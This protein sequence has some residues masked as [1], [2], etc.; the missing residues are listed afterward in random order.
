M[1]LENKYII[2]K[3]KFEVV[4]KY[5]SYYL[6][7]YVSTIKSRYEKLLNTRIQSMITIKLIS[8]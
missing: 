3:N 2:I 7:V 6:K 1:I 8:L 4:P 5:L